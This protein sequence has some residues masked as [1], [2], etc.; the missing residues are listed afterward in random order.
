MKSDILTIFIDYSLHRN[1]FFTNI[2]A[3][4]K[5]TTW[6]IRIRIHIFDFI[7]LLE[8]KCDLFSLNLVDPLI[9]KVTFF[10]PKTFERYVQAKSGKP[11]SWSLFQWNRW[12]DFNVSLNAPYS[13]FKEFDILKF[14]Y[15]LSLA[16][17]A[18]NSMWSENMEIV[19]IVSTTWI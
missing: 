6:S 5:C 7:F 19:E 11:R 17:S 1:Y 9:T 10:S 13:E 14:Q 16:F 4:S 12:N 2:F 8:I 15:K 3:S 18:V